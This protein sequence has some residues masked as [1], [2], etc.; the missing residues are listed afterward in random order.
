MAKA[1]EI[2]QQILKLP[3]PDI[4]AVQKIDHW[5]TALYWLRNDIKPSVHAVFYFW[6]DENNTFGPYTFIELAKVKS[7]CEIFLRIPS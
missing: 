2:C 7:K 6:D 5:S 1:L 3:M 4:K